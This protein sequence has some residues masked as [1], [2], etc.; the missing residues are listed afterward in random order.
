MASTALSIQG[1][2][3][4]LSIWALLA[5]ISISLGVYGSASTPSPPPDT[6]SLVRDP[7][8]LLG[9]PMGL[10]IGLQQGFIY[11]TYIKVSYGGIIFDIEVE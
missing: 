7:R 4:L 11:T 1:R 6:R 9:I 2:T 10:F 5:F 3:V 8:T